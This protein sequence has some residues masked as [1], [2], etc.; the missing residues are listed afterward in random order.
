MKKTIR[1]IT[2]CAL[3]ALGGLTIVNR[4]GS[5]AQR[6]TVNMDTDAVPTFYYS[7]EDEKAGAAKEKGSTGTIAIIIGAVV[8]VGAG[9]FF[10]LKKKK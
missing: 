4:Q 9:A 6:D 3:M 7:V 2:L 1:I 8:I 10:L 5:Q